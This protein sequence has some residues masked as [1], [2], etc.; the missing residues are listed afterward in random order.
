MIL[1]S[2]V[3]GFI[4]FGVGVIIIGIIW[5][6]ADAELDDTKDEYSYSTPYLELMDTGWNAFPV[7]FLLIG[8]FSS[9]IGV[10]VSRVG[11]G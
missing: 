2:D 5:L 8:I 7:A 9:L 4:V 1:S 11:G 10:K 6:V 3:N